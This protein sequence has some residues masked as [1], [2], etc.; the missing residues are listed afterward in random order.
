MHAGQRQNDDTDVTCHAFMILVNTECHRST[1][2]LD[3]SGECYV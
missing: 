3:R 2:D 1:V